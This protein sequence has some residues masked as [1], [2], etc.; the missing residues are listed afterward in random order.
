VFLFKIIFGEMA[1]ILINGTRVSSEKI[2]AAGFVFEYSKIEDALED[3]L[4]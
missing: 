1:I 3:L 4:D 2:R